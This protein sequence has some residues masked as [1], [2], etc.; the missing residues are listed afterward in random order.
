MPRREGKNVHGFVVR[1]PPGKETAHA[2]HQPA[3]NRRGEGRL[4]RRFA[5][6]DVPKIRDWHPRYLKVETRKCC[7]RKGE[8]ISRRFEALQTRSISLPWN[9]KR[10]E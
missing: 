9:V 7:S 10:V 8:G 4:A 1:S 5:F 3:A 6:G 2:A